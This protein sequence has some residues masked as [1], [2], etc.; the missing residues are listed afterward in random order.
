ML[1]AHPEKGRL[2]DIDMIAFDQ[3]GEELQEEG[4]QQQ[5][6]VHAVDIRVGRND[7][8]VIAQ[9][10]KTIL[11]VKCRLQQVELLVLVDDLFG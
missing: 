9:S 10:V 6:D 1:V 7:D 11:D 3:V 4:D 8:L 2:Q 5:P